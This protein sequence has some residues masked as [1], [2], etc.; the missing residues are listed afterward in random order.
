MSTG[1]R[2]AWLA[3]PSDERPQGRA[4]GAG[5][6]ERA[7]LVHHRVRDAAHEVLAEP[8]LRVHDARRG[9]D[10]AVAEVGEMAGDRRRADVDRDAVDLL[11]ETGPDGRHVA[12]V[13]DSDRDRVAALLERRLE[14]PDDVEV[15]GQAGQVPLALEGV[16]EADQVTG[17]RGELGRRDL[18]VVEA[19]DRVDDEV[20]DRQALA[21]DLAVDLAVGRDVDDHVAAQV[22]GTRQPASL[23]EPLLAVVLGLALGRRGQ[24]VG[25][26]SDA[27]LGERAE[28]RHDLAATAEAA[29]ATDR[30]DVD[31]ERARGVEDRRPLG[32]PAAPAGRREDDEGIR[33]RLG[34]LGGGRR[35][36]REPL[37]RRSRRAGG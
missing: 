18:D 21:D 4:H 15:G 16:E 27:V 24:V 23:G 20:A 3:R 8:D 30:V 22:G 35:H 1:S 33:G 12:P 13:V 2:P 32:E 11:V 19:D 10:R 7:T 9:Q 26:G 37:S 14:R 31:A 25:A 6:L 28:R 34:G 17:R 29:P 5:H 36:G